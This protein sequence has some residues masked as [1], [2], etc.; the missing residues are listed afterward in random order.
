MKVRL[1]VRGRDCRRNLA[2]LFAVVLLI[3]QGLSAAH[4]HPRPGACDYSALAGISSDGGMCALCLFHCYSPPLLTAA[5]FPVPPA[6]VA[7]IDLYT[8][9]TWPLYSF[10][11]YLPGRAPPLFA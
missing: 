8:A 11:S 7:H 2:V 10:N 5:L 4:Y 9:E 3:A 6:I 1:E